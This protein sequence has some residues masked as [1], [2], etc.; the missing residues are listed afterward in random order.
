MIPILFPEPEPTDTD[1]ICEICRFRAAITCQ[2]FPIMCRYCKKRICYFCLDNHGTN[3][4]DRGKD[5]G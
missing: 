4:K 1:L 2:S 5:E 3:C